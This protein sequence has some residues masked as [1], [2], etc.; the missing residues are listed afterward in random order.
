MQPGLD[1]GHDPHSDDHGDDMALIAD[2]VD[3]DGEAAQ[4][5]QVPCGD[6]GQTA[7]GPGVDEVGV[8]HNHADD[9][10]QVD[11]AA[12]DAGS[13]GGDQHG[14]EDECGVGEHIQNGEPVA[15]AEAGDGLGQSLDQAHHQTGSHD[16]RQDGNKDVAHCLD[17]PLEDGLLGSGGSLDLV[18]G[19]G[20]QAG[21]GQEL[22]VDLVDGAG[23]NDQLELTIALEDTLNAVDVL[24]G[25]Q[26][27]LA[28]VHGDQAQASRAV[29]GA[30]Q[31][32][33]A[34]KSLVDLFGA[35]CVIQCHLI[36][37]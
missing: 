9:C 28:V 20:G 32:L 12:E 35:G 7:H 24:Q 13:G 5:Q 30:D 1:L 2:L 21:H 4:V 23:A 19:G 8:D 36:S 3:G 26:V 17:H 10:A 33:A 37:S 18:L 31:V 14:Q 27:D 11:V 22:L 15:A 29:R 34:A 6:L 25:V 16:G